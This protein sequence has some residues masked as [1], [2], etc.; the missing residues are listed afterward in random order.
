MSRFSRGTALITG[1][2]TGIGRELALA[3]AK[4]HPQVVLVARDQARLE[5]VATEIG[6]IEGMRPP[7]VLPA[8]LS[9]AD[10]PRRIFEKLQGEH[11]TV[12]YLINNAGFGTHGLFYETDEKQTLD[13][14]A[15][16][17]TSLVHLTRLFLPGMV[18]RRHGRVLNV[19]S[20]AGFL[21]GPHMATYYASKAFVLSFTEALD[22]ELG[23]G[24]VRATALCPGP[25]ITEFQQRAGIQNSALFRGN[26]IDAATCARIGYR[27]M[28][29]GRRVVVPGF[30]SRMMAT[31]A[32]LVPRRL[33]TYLAGKLNK[34]R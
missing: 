2:S 4:D 7:L 27:A 8:D 20:I 34:D 12:D 18:E 21:P 16:N 26:S 5:S 29:A 33:A 6:T 3:I 17:M 24:D 22:A 1:A 31:S 10:S 14:L 25:V 11:I 9:Q 23:R 13:L 28:M 32:R 19:A 15:V 30:K